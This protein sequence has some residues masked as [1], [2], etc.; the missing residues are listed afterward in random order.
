MSYAETPADPAF[1]FLCDGGEMGRRIR[2]FP[3]AESPLGAPD[4]W[5]QV[6]RWA[7]SVCLNSTMPSAIYWS[8]HFVLLYNDAWIA[9]AGDRHPWALG[10]TAEQVWPDIWAV[11]AADFAKAFEQ[12]QG[13]A[14]Y[15]QMLPIKRGETV[16]ETFWNYSLTPLRDERGQVLGVLNQGHEVTHRVLQ[17]REQEQ[18]SARQQRMFEQA[19]GFITIVAGS[20]HRFEFVNDACKQLF[21]ERNYLGRSI[22]H[23]FPE[24]EGQGY[25][26]E[27]DAVYRTGQRFV[28]NAMP[29]D[30]VMDGQHVATRYLN[31]VY[32]PLL[33]SQGQ[34]TGVFCEGFDVTESYQANTALARSEER[35]RA[36]L[37]IETVGALFFDAEGRILDANV[38]FLKVSGY[39]LDQLRDEVAWQD[40]TPAQWHDLAVQ[41]LE[42]LRS[43]GQT[44]PYEKQYIRR[45]GSSWWGLAAVK[46][47]PDGT[48]FEFVVDISDRVLAQEA[49]KQETR[50]LGILRTLNSTFASDLNLER[51]VQSL[52]DSGTELVGAAFGSYFHNVLD[53]TGEYLKLYTLSG[54][55]REAFEKLGHPRATAIFTPTFLNEGV[56]RSDDILADPRYGLS[57]PHRGMPKGHLPVRSYLAISV[58][59]RTGKVL[60]GLFFGHPQ[61]GRFT[62]R[63]ER[64]MMTLAAN[65]AIAIDNAQLF[66]QVQQANETLEERVNQ[67]TQELTR[68]HEALRQSQKM[69]ALGQLTGGIAH[70][71][72]NL[73]AGILGSAELLERK[74]KQANSNGVEKLISAIHVSAKRAAA[75]TQRLLAFSRRQTLDPKPTAINQLV[76][77]MEELISRAVGPA[78]GV[79]ITTDPAAGV[80]KIDAAQLESSLL[81]LAINSR[82][83]MPGGGLITI[84]TEVIELDAFAASRVELPAG[85]Y[86]AVTVSDTGTGIAAVDLKRIF[87]PFFTTKPIGQGTGLGLSMVHGFVRQSGGQVEVISEEGEGTRFRLLLPRFHGLSMAEPATAHAP[88]VPATRVGAPI[89]VVD[90]EP[91]IRT[92]VVET[93]RNAGY[94]VL[95]AE[96]G[97]S[98][99]RLIDGSEAVELLI[100]DVGLPGGLNGRQVA[101]AARQRFA[102]L[103]VLF[104]TGYAESTVLG[105]GFMSGITE[106]V[107][108]PFSLSA[109]EQRVADMLKRTLQ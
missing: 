45:D 63:H 32:E 25:F 17:G 107:T 51:I 104:I 73:L 89:V 57:E 19:P 98:A 102:D 82:D 58:V 93:L 46:S 30:L 86:V 64:L 4:T 62:E 2:Q 80:A 68:T 29:I 35:F 94:A 100:T 40:L 43:R 47:M 66:L 33:D 7:V 88:M 99:L 77:G 84:T 96:D 48:F 76:E 34:V 23:V 65:A 8:E 18:A 106:V 69:E 42:E 3:W 12:G 83:A 10:R 105:E 28:A 74:L 78:I 27:L 79:V 81:N 90:D 22:R 75:L 16:T 71:F 5:P 11:V 92:L 109:L 101:D 54:A 91:A 53:E 37:D 36:A 108:K 61:P 70:D 44:S 52:T 41:A 38:G 13:V 39:T 26:E 72:N 24:L 21:G 6:L 1:H 55:S 20:D 95:E 67:R 50:T 15:E 14:A 56:V 9:V 85:D 103:K 87:D 49:L 59:S 97:A 60:G 31:F